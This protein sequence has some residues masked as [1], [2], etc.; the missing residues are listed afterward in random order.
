MW[1][2]QRMNHNEKN[3]LKLN[4]HIK[5]DGAKLEILIHLF[6]ILINLVFFQKCNQNWNPTKTN[7]EIAVP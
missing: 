1:P 2:Q 5:S 6:A 7:L 4:E 3:K